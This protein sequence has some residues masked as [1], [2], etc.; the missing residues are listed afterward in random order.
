M[1]IW[2]RTARLLQMFTMIYVVSIHLLVQKRHLVLDRP[3]VVLIHIKWMR[4]R[5]NGKF[6]FVRFLLF[7]LYSRSSASF[8]LLPKSTESFSE[9]I[10]TSDTVVLLDHP[11]NCSSTNIKLI[12]NKKRN[13]FANKYENR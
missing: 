10:N 7:S 12:E 3:S 11:R 9:Q 8:I 6:P 13:S 4:Q 1:Q 5:L 2:R